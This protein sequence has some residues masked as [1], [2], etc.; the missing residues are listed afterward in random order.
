MKLLAW[1]I[2]FVTCFVLFMFE[3]SAGNNGW[4]AIILLIGFTLLGPGFFKLKKRAFRTG[5]TGKLNPTPEEIE[6]AEKAEKWVGRFEI[7]HKITELF[8]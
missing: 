4:A 1:L 6:K 5:H 2:G 3:A 8:K 7:L